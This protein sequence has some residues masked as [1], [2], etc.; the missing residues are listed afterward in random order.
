MILAQVTGEYLFNLSRPSGA[1]Q[2]H[3]MAEVQQQRWDGAARQLADRIF[4][5]VREECIDPEGI[6]E[7]QAERTAEE[8]VRRIFDK[9][10]QP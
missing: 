7:S 10:W 1:A 8:V 2:W 9:D 3:E 5:A 6:Y 4:W